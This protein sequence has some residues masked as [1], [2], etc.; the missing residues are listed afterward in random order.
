VTLVSGLLQQALNGIVLG[1]SYALLALGLTV[2]WGLL[3]FVNFAHG[4]VYML[5]AFGA[6]YLS[7]LGLSWWW[8]LLVVPLVL[9][10]VGILVERLFVRRLLNVHHTYGFLF[11]Y[12]LALIAQNLIEA[13]YGV[14]SQ[15]Y[16]VPG[17]FAG[18]MNLFSV[19][20][21]I[22]PLFVFVVSLLLC[23][24]VGVILGKTRVGLVIRAAIEKPDMTRALGINVGRWIGPVFGSGIA[25][26]AFA[27]VLAAPVHAVSST[28]G[29][30][31]VVILFAVVIVGGLGS[32]FGSV[33][34]GFLFGLIQGVTAFFASTLSEVII[35]AFMALV[36]LVRPLGL[37]GREG[38]TE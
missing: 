37:F 35:F 26:A 13:R 23:L 30:D 15:P 7:G 27:G 5:G 22:Y 21:P 16:A 1:S 28:M 11:T 14:A 19:R 18:T 36:L 34:T 2:I 17:A 12:G 31:I 32:V 25:M 24:L 38:V 4:A 6:V 29:T 10:A 20:Y 3:R 8:C 33:L 9:G